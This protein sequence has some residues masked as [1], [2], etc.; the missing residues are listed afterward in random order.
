MTSV[1]PEIG[2]SHKS[3]ES[4]CFLKPD[5]NTIT[6]KG[7][8]FLLEITEKILVRCLGLPAS[9]QSKRSLRRKRHIEC[10]CFSW[11][12][13]IPKCINIGEMKSLASMGHPTHICHKKRISLEE[14]FRVGY[15]S[16]TVTFR[17][18]KHLQM[19]SHSWSIDSSHSSFF[20]N[21]I[22]LG[23]VKYICNRS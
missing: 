22:G 16:P 1:W 4:E 12:I 14:S 19:G 10:V 18:Y 5:P 15:R 7:Y 2:D 3:W 20:S 11:V 17:L 21:C 6:L 8:I 9:Q 13:F 23:C